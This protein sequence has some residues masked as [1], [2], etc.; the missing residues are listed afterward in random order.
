MELM[1]G[2]LARGIGLIYLIAFAQLFPQIITLAGAQGIAPVAEVLKAIRRDY[3][4]FRRILYF[5]TLLW[6]GASDRALKTILVAGCI[7]AIAVI[8]GGP[9]SPVAF[10]LCFVLMLS[11]SVAIDLPKPWDSLLDEAGF[12]A[13]FLPSLHVLPSLSATAPAPLL[14]AWAYRFLLF[15]LMFGFAKQK[16]I[17]STWADRDYMRGFY[18]SQPMP[19]YIGW[20]IQRMPM[21]FHYV[22][23][24]IMAFTELVVPF[25]MFVPGRLSIVAAIATSAL[26]LAIQA[27]GGYGFFN[28]LTIV[29]CVSLLDPRSFHLDV[30]NVPVLMVAIVVFVGGL[31]H[32]PF[33]TWVSRS[34]MFW[35]SLA[36]VRTF[37]L[38]HLLA[39]YRLLASFRIV[40]AYGVFPPNSTPPAR[41]LPVIE[42]TIDGK[43]WKEYEYRFMTCKATSPPRFTAP[44]QPRFEY[45]MIYEAYGS[46]FNGFF[47]SLAGTANPYRFTR[48]TALRCVLQRLLE[49]SEPIK[50]IFKEDPFPGQTPLE[51]RVSL[52]L[53]T[54]ANDGNWWV[55]RYVGPHYEPVRLERDFWQT[56][57]PHPEIFHPDEVAWRKR[58]RKSAD[59][60][61]NI[62]EFWETFIPFVRTL[63]RTNWKEISQ[64]V[65]QVR[66]RFD[67]QKLRRFERVM[68]RLS[69]DL[70]DN[71]EVGAASFFHH[72][73]LAYYVVGQGRESF[74]QALG[75]RN[76]LA[77]LSKTMAPQEGLFYL[78]LF[79][80]DTLEFH[81]KKIRL[82]QKLVQSDAPPP[83]P[84]KGVPGFTLLLPFLTEHFKSPEEALIPKPTRVAAG[85]WRFLN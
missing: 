56:W 45:C 8:V 73:L 47:S 3:T 22:C 19:T 23:L 42:G 57:L 25:F 11:L 9:F 66:S 59:V 41:W 48:R 2:I 15:R 77:D 67:V 28:L 46:N 35:P 61:E 80:H 36:Q 24:V 37:G 20:Y 16:F 58:A 53:F 18:I 27:T 44:F 51:L 1:W 32:F 78:T 49:G 85:E 12:L 71:S 10:L 6:L 60:V 84:P 39:F 79:W 76:Y 33:N 63:D 14:I 62:E 72:V 17:G 68:G 83:P 5:P 43:T 38:R 74:K 40:H 31:I 70:S 13:I 30:S 52:M 21:W 69:T 64:T 26:M 82:L 75:D 4:P 29:L 55:R 81:A 34:C 65:A 54:P 50:R 7:A